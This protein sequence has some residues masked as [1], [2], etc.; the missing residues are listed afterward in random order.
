MAYHDP[1]VLGAFR[2]TLTEELLEAQREMNAA[3]N[4]QI[5]FRS[6]YPLPPLTRRRRLRHKLYAWQQDHRE[7]LALTIAPWLRDYCD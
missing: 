6:Q 1:H 5:A 7:R 4:R 2:Q 3:M